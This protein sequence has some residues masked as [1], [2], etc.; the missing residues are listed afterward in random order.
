[1]NGLPEACL[2]N[3]FQRG[4]MSVVGLSVSK[5]TAKLQRYCAW[6]GRIKGSK[7]S[8]GE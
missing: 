7:V 6:Y 2:V 5:K 4:K 1:L 3:V 8:N